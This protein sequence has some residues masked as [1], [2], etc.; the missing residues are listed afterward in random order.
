MSVFEALGSTPPLPPP[1]IPNTA[2]QKF[3]CILKEKG[4]V[5]LAWSL[6]LSALSLNISHLLM[7]AAVGWNTRPFQEEDVWKVK[8][9]INSGSGRSAQSP[10]KLVGFFFLNLCECH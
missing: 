4:I 3:I 2:K 1:S 5:P 7:F 6:K 8:I 9:V 10:T